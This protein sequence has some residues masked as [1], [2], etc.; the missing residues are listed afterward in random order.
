MS[1]DLRAAGILLA[2]SLSNEEKEELSREN[3]CNCL[4]GGGDAAIKSGMTLKLSALGIGGVRA[5][6]SKHTHY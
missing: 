3:S 2:M 6:P 1:P 4:G 5:Q